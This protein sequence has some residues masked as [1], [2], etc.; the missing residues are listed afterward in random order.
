MIPLIPEPSFLAS[1]AAF[2]DFI[3]AFERGDWPKSMW[4]HAAHLA[5]ATW[6]LLLL[7]EAE[8]TERVRQGIRSYNEAVGTRNT[9]DSGYHETL[10]LFWLGIIAARLSWPEVPRNPL[11]AARW[12][13]AEFGSRRDLFRDYYSFDVVNSRE[14]RAKWVPPTSSKILGNKNC[15]RDI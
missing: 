9:E 11:D 12:I 13:V 10:T 15:E 7:P 4:T 1:E 2:A 3:A 6:Y 5:V 14:A 8:A